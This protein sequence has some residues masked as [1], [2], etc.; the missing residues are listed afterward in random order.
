[1]KARITLISL[2]TCATLGAVGILSER[3][4]LIDQKRKPSELACSYLGRSGVFVVPFARIEDSAYGASR[5][6]II[7]Q[8][9]SFQY[10]K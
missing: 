6:P 1:M 5:C 7:F 3:S 2:A 8:G 9:H 10:F 4:L